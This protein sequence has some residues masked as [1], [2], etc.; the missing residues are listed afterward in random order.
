MDNIKSFLVVPAVR[1]QIA[2][3]DFFSK[4]GAWA[5]RVFAVLFL[6]G[7]IIG[8]VQLWKAVFELNGAG[9]L[10]GIL[11]QVCFVIGAYLALQVLWIGAGLL[12]AQRDEDFRVIPL[13]PIFLRMSGE[14][15]A[16]VALSFGFAKGLLRLF[17]DHGRLVENINSAIPGIGW[18][19]AFLK[20]LFGGNEG[21]SGFVNAVLFML[22]G[23]VSA[24]LWLAV[25]YLSAEFILLL[26]GIARDLRK[27]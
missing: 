13:L 5:V 15:Y 21:V 4:T 2:R 25:F 1:E 3:A 20:Q 8:W 22:G 10:G 23:V 9:I 26:L 7:A 27:R 12:E 17:V 18:E 11:F 24:V 14:L 6:L 16:S 19:H